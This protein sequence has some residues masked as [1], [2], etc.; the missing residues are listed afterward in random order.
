M[1]CGRSRTGATSRTL[2]RRARR[3]RYRTGEERYEQGTVRAAR[4][5]LAGL[6]RISWVIGGGESG[7]KARP[8]HPGWFRSLRDQCTAG[9]VPFLFKQHGEW[10]ERGNPE[11]PLGDAW[12]NPQRHRL[13]SPVDGKV[14]PFGEFTGTDGAWGWAHV[15]R[16][17]KKA[18]GR[19]LDGQTWDEFPRDEQRTAA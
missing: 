13:V 12:K 10:S 7:P 2:A 18:A 11:W 8:S 16:V 5:E 4:F 9:N 19:V 1:T 17:G 15:K 14:K 6:G 3:A